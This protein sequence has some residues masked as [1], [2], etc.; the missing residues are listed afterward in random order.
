MCIYSDNSD[1]IAYARELIECMQLQ[2][3]VYEEWVEVMRDYSTVFC[4]H[5]DMN[6]GVD[7]TDLNQDDDDHDGGQDDNA[8]YCTDG[9]SSSKRALKSNGRSSRTALQ[10]S[11]DVSS[12]L[13]I[14][15]FD[16]YL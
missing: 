9:N 14:V 1:D 12:P 5:S 2:A 11:A 7:E 16:D 13:L 15:L 4:L 8:D 3:K 10:K 6:D